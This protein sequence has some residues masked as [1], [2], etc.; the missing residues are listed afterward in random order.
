MKP[1]LDNAAE[2]PKAISEF[3]KR[4][5]SI[6][7]RYRIIRK[8]LSNEKIY[9]DLSLI[10][11][12][13]EELEILRAFLEEISDNIRVDEW[14]KANESF[15]VAGAV[16]SGSQRNEE[17]FLKEIDAAVARELFTNDRL[18]R[19]DVM[20]AVKLELELDDKYDEYLENTLDRMCEEYNIREDGTI[21][22]EKEEAS[23][24]DVQEV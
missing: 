10:V 12:T 18:K 1:T 14:F 20:E 17:D 9:S 8:N 24:D 15:A 19:K 6:K 2:N 11:N 4:Y 16:M 3:L 23:S 7:T 5:R 22:P 13:S 21:I